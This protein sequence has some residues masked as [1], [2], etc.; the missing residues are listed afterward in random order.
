[1]LVGSAIVRSVRAK[2]QVV[3]RVMH[4]ARIHQLTRGEIVYA[5]CKQV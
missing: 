3:D 5:V 4:A 2:G 1:V